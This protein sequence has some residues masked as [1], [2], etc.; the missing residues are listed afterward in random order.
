VDVKVSY[1]DGLS[2]GELF[3][4]TSQEMISAGMKWVQTVMSG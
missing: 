3:S 1:D 2:S 4:R